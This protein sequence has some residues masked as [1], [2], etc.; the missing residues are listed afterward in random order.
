LYNI[1]KKY[2]ISHF[3]HKSDAYQLHTYIHMP[4][5]FNLKIM[6]WEFYKSY[7]FIVKITR[8][9]QFL[10]STLQIITKYISLEQTNTNLQ[11]SRSSLERRTL[12]LSW[13]E[14]SSRYSLT[15][16]LLARPVFKSS[17]ATCTCLIQ[18]I[19]RVH[20]GPSTIN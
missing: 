11:W 1:F 7:F 9:I 18:L 20:T 4:N 16:K 12:Q 6:R 3:K 14:F 10:D 19:S 17:I 5:N 13:V 8:K 2:E 15:K